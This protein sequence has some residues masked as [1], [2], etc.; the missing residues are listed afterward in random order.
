MKATVK[1]G[2]YRKETSSKNKILLFL[3]GTIKRV[4]SL[5]F[6]FYWY[7]K[8][9]DISLRSE[10]PIVFFSTLWSAFFSLGYIALYI[11]AYRRQGKERS[12]FLPF[13]GSLNGLFLVLA[14]LTTLEIMGYMNEWAEA[15]LYSSVLLGL[16]G[17]EISK[18]KGSRLMLFCVVVLAAWALSVYIQPQAPETLWILGVSHPIFSSS[19]FKT[20]CFM[21]AL[22]IPIL[23]EREI[24]KTEELDCGLLLTLWCILFYFFS[25]TAVG[26]AHG[27]DYEVLK[28]LSALQI[29]SL[30]TFCVFNSPPALLKIGDLGRSLLM[31]QIAVLFCLLG[32]P[33]FFIIFVGLCFCLFSLMKKEIARHRNHILFILGINLSM[34]FLFFLMLKTLQWSVPLY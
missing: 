9:M 21:I 28:N 14:Q 12:P 1:K 13:E 10:M 17:Y 32:M 19:V 15:W 5:E 22:S 16:L 29:G 33:L 3:S 31:S 26:A 6:Y 23:L 8:K 2:L 27:W 11:F 4:F 24:K 34:G 7:T 18:N 20:V 30:A 25:R